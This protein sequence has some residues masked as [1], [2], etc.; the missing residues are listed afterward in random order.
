MENHEVSLDLGGMAVIAEVR[1]NG[2]TLGVLWHPPFLIEV[3]KSLQ[4]GSNSLEIDV[5]NL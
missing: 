2:N 5:N 3:S 4:P 1:L